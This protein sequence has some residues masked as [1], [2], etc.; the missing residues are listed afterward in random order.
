MHKFSRIFLS[1]CLLTGSTFATEPEKPLAVDALKLAEQKTFIYQSVP[2]RTVAYKM[3]EV[4]PQVTGIIKQRL[5]EEGS[6]VKEGDVL[7]QIDDD[8]YQVALESAQADL[9]K[10]NANENAVQVKRRRLKELV[11]NSAV[12]KQEYDDILAELA[13]S[14]ADIAI[15]EAQVAEAKLNLDYTRVL[16]PI[17]GLTGKSHVSD[18]ALVIANQQTSLVVVTQLDPAY[19][20]MTISTAELMRLKPYLADLKSIPVVLTLEPDNLRYE[21]EGTLQFSEVTVDQSTGSVQLWA[22]FPNPNK[23]LLPGLFVRASLRL[24]LENAILVPQLATTRQPD[25]SLS[26]WIVNTENKIEKR[27]VSADQAIR[28]Y[29]LVKEGLKEKDVVVT[30]GMVKI[31][32]GSTVTAEIVEQEPISIT[33]GGR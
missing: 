4:R 9:K 31:K 25:G 15:A 22:L 30:S 32:D 14:Q 21:H 29:W 19:V 27:T 33:S 26:A 17:S 28:N 18:G 20:S 23:R 12:S 6:E 10:A 2:G 11:G 24:P 13:K 3:A 16:A 5:F 1:F 7:Y 8:L